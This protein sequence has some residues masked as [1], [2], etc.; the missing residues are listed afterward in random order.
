MWNVFERLW[1]G[2]GT[3]LGVFFGCPGKS[4]TLSQKEKDDEDSEFSS[5]EFFVEGVPDL[6]GIR[7]HLV[8]P[9]THFV[10]CMTE[11]YLRIDAR[12]A[13]YIRTHHHTCMARNP[14]FINH[15]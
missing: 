3:I 1:G 13:D 14:K 15:A 8:H 2:I 5:Q 6:K 11:I 10:P 12:M 7:K 9:P 4:A